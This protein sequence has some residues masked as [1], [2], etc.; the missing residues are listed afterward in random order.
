LDALQRK[1]DDGPRDAIAAARQLVH[2]DRPAPALAA[3]VASLIYKCRP[4]VAG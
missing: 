1:M 2:A 3:E 4:N